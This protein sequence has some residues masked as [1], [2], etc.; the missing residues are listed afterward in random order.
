MA[1]VAHWPQAGGE[2]GALIRAHDW[3]ET[4]LGPVQEWPGSL[5]TVTELVLAMPQPAFTCW[6]SDLCLLYNDEYRAILGTKHP[7]ALGRP[8]GEIFPELAGTLLPASAAVLAGQPQ[9]WDADTEFALAGRGDGLVPGWF[10]ATWTPVRDDAGCVGGFVGVATETTD[11]VLA[12]RAQRTSQ[13]RQAFVLKL[14]DALRPLADPLAMQAAAAHV[15]G[16]HLRASRVFYG[17][18]SA[19][20]ADLLVDQNYVPDGQPVLAGRF[21]MAEFGTVMVAAL[22]AGRT[23]VVPDIG[24]SAELSASE[25]AAYDRLG[26]AALVGVPLVKGGRFVAT[27]TIQQVLPRAWTDEEVALMQET[28]ERTWA[29]VERARV[30]AALRRQQADLRQITDAV[31][32]LI[33]YQDREQRYQ[34]VNAGFER[35]FGAPREQIL[36]HTMREWLGERVYQRLRPGVERALAGETVSFEDCEPDKFGPGLDGWTEEHYLPRF[37]ADG[38]VEGFFVLA[39]DITERKEVEEEL[40]RANERFR[41]AEQAANGFVY[42]WDVA[43]LTAADSQLTTWTTPGVVSKSLD[44]VTVTCSDGIAAVLGYA[45]QDV[46]RSRAGWGALIHPDDLK[47]VSAEYELGVRAG[48]YSVEYRLRHQDG[49]YI[50]VLDRGLTIRNERG[51][52][53]R[54]I[55]SVVEI[56]ERK[57]AEAV[58]EASAA[59]QAFR[60]RLSDTLRPLADPLAIQ[61]AAARLLRE[62]LG[63]NQVHY[64]E[65]VADTGDEATVLVREGHGDGLPP[66]VGTFRHRAQGWGERLLATY[67]AGRTA[68]CYE[69][70]TDPTIT[71]EEAAVMTGAGFRAYV[72]VPLV[73]A[74]TWVATLAVHS[75]APRAWTADEVELVEETAERTWAAVERARAEAA[76]RI[77]EERLRVATRSARISTFEIDVATGTVAFDANV[78]VVLYGLESEEVDEHP[79]GWLPLVEAWLRPADAKRHTELLLATMRGEGDLHHEL[80]VRN[81]ESGAETWIEAY[82]SLVRDAAGRPSRVVGIMRDI[83]EQKRAEAERERLAATDAVAAERQAL[84]KR[85]VRVQEEERARVSR[86]IHDSVTQ[87][88]HAAAIH[89]DLALE[90]LDGSPP[91]AHQ[92]VERGRDLARAAANEARRLIAGLRPETLDMLGLSGALQQE[93]ETLRAAGWPVDFEDGD[94]AGMR[95]DPEAEITLFRVVQEAL[96]N[97]RKHAGHARVRVRLTRRNGSVRLEVRD[98]GRGFDPKAVKST[99]RGEQVGLVGIRERMHL[100]GGRVEVRSSA[101]TGTTI[102]ATLPVAGR[103]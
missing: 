6:G 92:E 95:L 27:L 5:R 9:R 73:K 97:V 32:A 94:L 57:R 54:I 78:R 81:P 64:S 55:G 50:Q 86:E 4:P 60:L 103:H 91:A 66:M 23:I 79:H 75:I 31:P 47:R 15:L 36:G 18:V 40:R 59:R 72:A 51:Q 26:I 82:A 67:R 41:L 7:A 98:W 71:A 88:T 42:D 1:Q 14:S 3:A 38:Q 56:T 11:R 90:L 89:L 34:W 80:L 37:A 63:A 58:L 68:V 17:E 21:R 13:A 87:L 70:D 99:A 96:S 101:D 69:V 12:E 28:A 52:I 49:R 44:A 45:Q 16:E 83:T 8:L 24:S 77:S 25:R 53:C 85:F 29:A 22:T 100:L 35:F 43:V 48:R 20:G 76:L 33:G 93:V 30:E 19:N 102:R 74:G 62:H 39:L 46:P 2:M 65:T 84:L 61:A 10:T